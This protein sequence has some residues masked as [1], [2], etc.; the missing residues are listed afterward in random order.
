[1]ARISRKSLGSFY[2][3]HQSSLYTFIMLAAERVLQMCIGLWIASHIA[4]RFDHATFAN[5][6]IAMSL[7]LVFGTIGSISG[8][9]VLLPRICAEPPDTLPRLWN[10]ALA[11]KII[12]G[13]LTAVPLV[14]WC[15]TMP[16]PTILQLALLWAVVLLIGQP[17]SLAVH[18]LYAQENFRFPQIARIIGMFT[19]LGVVV[20]VMAVGGPVTW[21]VWG[22]IGEI[23]MLTVLLCWRWIPQRR[24][25]LGLVD[26]KLMF[27]L[28]A[29]GA[30]LA[31][32]SSA[33]VALSRIDRVTLGK[34]MP[35]DV[36]SQYA[37]AM[38][39]LEAA[40]AFGAML[41]VVV[42]AKTLFKPGAINRNHH[43][44]LALFAGG[45]AFCLTLVLDLIANPL[46]TAIYG[47]KYADSATY[48]RIAAGLLPLVFA[49]AILQAPL[50]IRA[51]KT[52]HVTKAVTAFGLGAA[53]ATLAA[54]HEMYTWISA[55]AY[56]GYLTLIL[57]DLFELRRRSAEIYGTAA[58]PA[59]EGTEGTVAAASAPVADAT[60]PTPATAPVP[61]SAVPTLASATSTP[62][63]STPASPASPGA[64][65]TPATE[66][67]S[68]PT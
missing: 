6:Q 68:N 40:F 43:I 5:W 7:W 15:A 16:D 46:M 31:V 58:S 11:A 57:F 33:S 14:L 35:A 45:I 39:L 30:A 9:R 1:M 60:S 34:T 53:V 21:V 47:A 12:S 36:L 13:L 38:T 59:T 8:E 56:V 62:A 24:I 22:W 32:A 44:G 48:L 37:A 18:E 25:H 54:H 49:Q 27:N 42:G 61:T 55:G 50:L 23:G 28:F 52:Y 20:W 19:R 64:P 66:P 29:Q 51:T 3:T 4:R 17:V 65:A 67:H 2:R 26:W 63:A 10:T 41:A